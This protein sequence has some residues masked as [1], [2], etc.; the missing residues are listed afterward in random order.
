MNIAM[1]IREESKKE[2]NKNGCEQ[3]EN[4]ERHKLQG[5]H[6]MWFM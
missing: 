1:V 6:H 2:I 3:I 4:A 5:K